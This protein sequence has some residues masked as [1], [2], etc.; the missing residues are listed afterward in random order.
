M[1][2]CV[3]PQLVTPPREITALCQSNS[4]YNIQSLLQLWLQP[5]LQG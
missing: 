2:S 3:I 5:L 1:V 4:Y